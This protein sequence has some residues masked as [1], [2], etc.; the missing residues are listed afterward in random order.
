[1]LSMNCRRLLLLIAVPM[2]VSRPALAECLDV[3]IHTFARLAGVVFSGTVTTI[4]SRGVSKQLTGDAMRGEAITFAV[5][6]VW[7]GSVSKQFVVYNIGYSIESMW[8]I[9]GTKYLVFAYPHSRE[10]RAALG[11]AV[12]GPPTFGIGSCGQGTRFYERATDEILK[13]GVGRPPTPN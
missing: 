5:D 6:R 11:L 9:G 13:L 4:E 10:E 8:F 1:M 12:S 3:D 7:K 2:L